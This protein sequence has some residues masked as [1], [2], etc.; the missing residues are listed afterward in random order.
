MILCFLG[1]VL[2]W[3]LLYQLQ[4]WEHKDETPEE[5]E[6]RYRLTIGV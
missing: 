5:R 2:F 1:C 3:S 6:K 4:K